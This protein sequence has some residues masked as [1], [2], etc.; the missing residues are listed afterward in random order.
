MG[1]VNRP[2]VSP[3]NEAKAIS[4]PSCTCHAATNLDPN[5]PVFSLELFLSNL[6]NIL[7]GWDMHTPQKVARHRSV[8]DF[9]GFRSRDWNAQLSIG[10]W[11][12]CHFWL[13]E[14]IWA[15][16]KES[17]SCFNRNYKG[18]C[19]SLQSTIDLFFVARLFL[20]T[21]PWVW[22]LRQP[23]K[24]SKLKGTNAYQ[25]YKDLHRFNHYSISIVSFWTRVTGS[26]KKSRRP[27]RK[28]SNEQRRLSQK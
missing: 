27:R 19:S 12:M 9:C 28:K 7:P 6:K 4:G 24:Q 23:I 8:V 14:A 5:L 1:M 18:S 25:Q 16:K 13:P 21:S 15:T 20:G 22:F 17:C 26:L 3:W 2:L 11:P 10:E